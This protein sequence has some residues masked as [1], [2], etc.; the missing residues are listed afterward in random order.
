[1]T[2]GKASRRNTATTSPRSSSSTST[3]P[4]PE[5]QSSSPSSAQPKQQQ[6]LLTAEQKKLNHIHSEQKRRANIRRGY[7]ALCD[8]VP[9]LREAIKAEDVECA[10]TGKK[11]GRGKLLGEDGEKMDG[12]AGPRS[13]SVVLQKTIEHMHELLAQRSSY[14]ERLQAARAA[15]PPGHPALL[16]SPQP[17]PWDKIWNGG[18]GLPLGGEPMDQDGDD[19]DAGSEDGD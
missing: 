11:R 1:P 12:R 13:E 5:A 8:V 15:L 18:V 16:S 2:N 19:D 7:D 14:L 4:P 3:P 6:Q 17:E 10:Q 9:A